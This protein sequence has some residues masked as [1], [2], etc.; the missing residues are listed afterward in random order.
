M[1]STRWKATGLEIE[2]D[3][4]VAAPAEAVW[5]ALTDPNAMGPHLPGTANVTSTGPETI[6]VSIKISMGFLRPTVNVDVQL[7]NISPTSS[8][9]FEFSGKSMGAGVEGAVA[10]ALNQ[11]ESPNAESTQVTRVRMT[12]AVQ[13]SGLLRTVADSKLEAA[14]AGFLDEYFGSVERAN[15]R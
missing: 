15:S 13:T 14:A 2:Y 10:V 5:A 11:D 1:S 12:G 3:R 8:F 9:R 7:S 6:R 4:L